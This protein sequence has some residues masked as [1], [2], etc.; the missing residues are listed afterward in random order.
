ML[1]VTSPD[2][3]YEMLAFPA[4]EVEEGKRP[5]FGIIER[6]T[7]NLVWSAPGEHGDPIR[8]EETACWSPDSERVAYS[9]RVGT[10]YL[11]TFLIERS[12]D[13]FTEVSWEGAAE[14]E[15]LCDEKIL[16]AAREAGFGDG[17]SLGQNIGAETKPLRWIGPEA[18]VVRR[19]ATST[20]VEGEN[21]ASFTA[22]VTM[23]VGRDPTTGRFVK[24]REIEE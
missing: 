5:P 12:G 10:R 2:G 17:A 11:S 8:P 22:E 20:V 16:A 24:V 4:E 13:R 6:A 1:P 14:M 21:S 19:V 15:N 7:G 3:R 23:Q 9:T 18:L